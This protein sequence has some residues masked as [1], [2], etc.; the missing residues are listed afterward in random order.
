MANTFSKSAK[1]SLST[2]DVTVSSATNIFTVP[3]GAVAVILSV[4]IS[5]KTGSTTTANVYLLASSGDPTFFIKN[6][7]VPTGTSL[8]LISNN[9]IILTQN[10]V[11]RASA[12]TAS[13]L[14]ITVSYLLQT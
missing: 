8:E 10:D 4:L 5:N 1:S 14:D 7:S 2:A 11:L 12:G 6:G 3:A 9:K 13:A